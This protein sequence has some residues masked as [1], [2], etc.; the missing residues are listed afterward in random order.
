MYS[1]YIQTY[2]IEEQ[3]ERKN[4][5]SK[6][7]ERTGEQLDQDETKRD[8]SKQTKPGQSR[9]GKPGQTR[10]EGARPELPGSSPSSEAGRCPGCL[11]AWLPGWLPGDVRG[12]RSPEEQNSG[13]GTRWNGTCFRVYIYI[14]IY[15]YIYIERES[16]RTKTGISGTTIR[17]MG[18]RWTAVKRKMSEAMEQNSRR[19]RRRTR[20]TW[21]SGPSRASWSG[22]ARTA[23]PSPAQA[24]QGHGRPAALRSCRTSGS[25]GRSAG[26]GDRGAFSQ[27][28]RSP[29]VS[30]FL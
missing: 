3:R 8:K 14:Y 27:S 23:Q 12:P 10:E 26:C 15:R 17:A 13:N 11:A 1:I 28:T 25:P 24:R 29:I 7:K 20:R 21:T 30:I 22:A 4:P 2:I 16:E 6:K 5:C 9:A 19:R 18:D